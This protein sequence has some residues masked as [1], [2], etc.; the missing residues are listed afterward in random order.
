MSENIQLTSKTNAF[1]ADQ[2]SSND[3]TEILSFDA[4]RLKQYAMQDDS[5]CF[6]MPI[7]EGETIAA[8]SAVG[9]IFT[10]STEL[11]VL[12]TRFK[13][14]AQRGIIAAVSSDFFQTKTV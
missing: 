9:I 4:E 5:F 10:N 3:I 8:F 2:Y 14:L 7:A 6:W 11:A 12:S 13:E 1:N